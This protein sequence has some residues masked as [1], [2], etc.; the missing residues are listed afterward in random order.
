MESF[1]CLLSMTHQ[2]NIHQQCS[3]QVCLH[4]SKALDMYS[5]DVSSDTGYPDKVFSEVSQYPKARAMIVP[6]LGDD[7]LL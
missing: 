2:T 4:R 6:Q 1:A 7:C 5:A 3:D